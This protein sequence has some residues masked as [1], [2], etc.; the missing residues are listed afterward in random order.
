[1]RSLF[2]R[3]KDKLKLKFDEEWGAF[4]VVFKNRILYTGS[5]EMCEVFMK[6]HKSASAT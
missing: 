4:V 6:N 2:S 3:S 1:M 5:R